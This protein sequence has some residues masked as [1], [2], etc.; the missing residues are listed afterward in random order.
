MKGGEDLISSYAPIHIAIPN[1]YIL[2]PGSVAI[3]T[4]MTYSLTAGLGSFNF[5][6]RTVVVAE[7]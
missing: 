1:I 6:A 4:L 5:I 3:A 2:S 7:N